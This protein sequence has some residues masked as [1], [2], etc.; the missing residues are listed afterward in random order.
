MGKSRIQI[1]IWLCVSG[2]TVTGCIGGSDENTTPNALIVEEPVHY[3]GSLAREPMIVEHPSGTLFVTGYNN[4]SVSPQLWRSEN[5]GAT[6]E[7]VNVGTPAEGA[8]GDSCVDL[9]IGPD[10]TIYFMAMEY[11]PKTQDDSTGSMEGK[12]IAVGVSHDVGMTWS[13]TYLSQDRGDDRPWVRVAQDGK[14]HAIW[15]DGKGVSHAIS[16]DGGRTWDEQERIHP[17]G[18][19]SHLAIGPN[20]EVA[21]RITPISASGNQYDE[22]L[23]LIAVSTD[24]GQTWQKHTPPGTREWDPTINDPDKIP[25]WVE[26]IAWDTKGALY[27]LWSEG[28]DLWLGRS[29]DKGNTWKSWVVAHDDDQVFFPYLVANG[30]S[31]LAFTWFSGRDDSLRAHVARIEMPAG[32]DGETPHVRESEPLQLDI[33]SSNSP[34]TRSTGGEYIPVI[35]LSD[36]SLGV[37]TPIQNRHEGRLGF[38]WWRI[39]GN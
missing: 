37:V 25:R 22:G 17:R 24:G 1:V 26:P 4:K 29:E 28:R 33:W 16:S 11:G 31:E 6:W 30:S 15:N 32:D 5:G 12:H 9:A 36:G 27:Y 23:E 14:A 39:I 7:P 3:T 21:V 10:G 2:L 20:G 18:L 38:T 19:S 35:F 8:D 34:P 13:W